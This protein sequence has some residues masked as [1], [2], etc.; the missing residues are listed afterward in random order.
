MPFCLKFD[1]GAPNPEF[2]LSHPRC[3]RRFVAETTLQSPEI[4]G[5]L[6]TQVVESNKVKMLDKLLISRLEIR[7][8]HGSLKQMNEI[9]ASEGFQPDQG[10]IRVRLRPTGFPTSNESHNEQLTFHSLRKWWRGIGFPFVLLWQTN[11]GPAPS[12]K[13]KKAH[14]PGLNFFRP[15]RPQCA[16]RASLVTCRSNRSMARPMLF[17][18]RWQ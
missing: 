15:S 7:F 17:S 9:K 10:N 3:C 14:R 13:A 4:A 2:P 18:D 11:T 12:A 1:S 5:K 16:S 8:L 6:T